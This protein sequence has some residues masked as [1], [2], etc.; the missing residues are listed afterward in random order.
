MKSTIKTV[1][2]WLFNRGV[3]GMTATIWLFAAFNLRSA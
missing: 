3:L 1:T 2:M